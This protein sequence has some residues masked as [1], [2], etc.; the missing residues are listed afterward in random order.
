MRLLKNR[1]D[2]GL[3]GLAVCASFACMVHCLL[4]PVLLGL[5]PAL[6]A[7]IDPGPH[8]HAIVLAL[9]APTSAFAL[10]SG[11]RR[12]GRPVPLAAGVLGLSC[13][14]AGLALGEEGL[15]ETAATLAGGLMLAAAHLG[16]WRYRRRACPASAR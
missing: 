5:L 2:D 8:F 9:A 15:A 12:H 16:N 10:L 14:A 11:W 4:L 6:T 7:R 3:D 13:M 1:L